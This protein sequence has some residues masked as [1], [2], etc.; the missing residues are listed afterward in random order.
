MNIKHF[1]LRY[2]NLDSHNKI[3]EP[4]HLNFFQISCFIREECERSW[5][6]AKNTSDLKL[7]VSKFKASQ[8]NLLFSCKIYFHKYPQSMFC[9]TEYVYILN[10]YSTKNVLTEVCN[11]IRKHKI[12]EFRLMFP[13]TSF[14][15]VFLLLNNKLSMATIL[16]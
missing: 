12:Y 10:E 15:F 1:I 3:L 4:D 2:F 8:N 6:Y 16:E 9:E 14:S 5:I 7:F 11:T 13:I